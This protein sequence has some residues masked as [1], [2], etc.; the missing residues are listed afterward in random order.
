MKAEK[1]IL[2]SGE[3][4]KR[5]GAPKNGRTQEKELTGKSYGNGGDHPDPKAVLGQ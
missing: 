3:P 1:E 5:A 2:G 4:T